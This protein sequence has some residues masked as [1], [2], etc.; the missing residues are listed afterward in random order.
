MSATM[1]IIN[2]FLAHSNP[3]F[4]CVYTFICLLYAIAAVDVVIV[5]SLHNEFD[6]SGH[7]ECARVFISLCFVLLLFSFYYIIVLFCSVAAIFV[8]VV[9]AAAMLGK[10]DNAF[11]VELSSICRNQN[12]EY[13]CRQRR[14][15]IQ[16]DVRI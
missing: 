10:N 11:L 12:V 8:V 13:V 3:T 16:I 2:L 9:V 5:N 14:Q 7:F 4:L 6:A 1:R 15:V